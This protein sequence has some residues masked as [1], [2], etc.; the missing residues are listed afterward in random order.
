[1]PCAVFKVRQVDVHHALHDPQNLRVLITAAIVNEGK[2]QTSLAGGEKGLHD[3]RYLGSGRN[4]LDVV[5]VLFLKRQ[6]DTGK[7]FSVCQLPG[8]V[9]A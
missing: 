5:T 2:K 1:M 4:R 9:M 7:S 8:N 3:L 6:Y